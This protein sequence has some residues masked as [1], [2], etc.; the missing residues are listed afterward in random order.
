MWNKE[1]EI[2]GI[3]SDEFTASIPNKP[4][5]KEEVMRMKTS[6]ISCLVQLVNDSGCTTGALPRAWQGQCCI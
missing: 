1:T 4:S 3:S 2:G 6:S 5:L